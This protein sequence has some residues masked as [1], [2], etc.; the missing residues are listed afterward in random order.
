M[1]EEVIVRQAW[2]TMDQNQRTDGGLE[3]AE[4]GV[5]C[6]ERLGGAGVGERREA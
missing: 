6:L 5:V 4:D 1:V 2:A 3:V